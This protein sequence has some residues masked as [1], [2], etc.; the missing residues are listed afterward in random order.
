M[1]F[2]QKRNVAHHCGE[3][4]ITGRVVLDDGEAGQLGLLLISDDAA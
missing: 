2:E 1:C 3:D 4:S